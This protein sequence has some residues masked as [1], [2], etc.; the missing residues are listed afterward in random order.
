MKMVVE[1]R[2][3]DEHNLYPPQAEWC[4]YPFLQSEHQWHRY[5]HPRNQSAH[6]HRCGGL[7][8]LKEIH[9]WR[10]RSHLIE[11]EEREY[12]R[13]TEAAHPSSTIAHPCPYGSRRRYRTGTNGKKVFDF[14]KGLIIQGNL[15][16]MKKQS[17]KLWIRQRCIWPQCLMHVVS[18]QMG[19]VDRTTGE[20]SPHQY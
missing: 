12:V 19:P 13:L 15:K 18:D 8:T 3:T 6:R 20:K 4:G 5:D 17:N 16:M 9:A 14:H 1:G 2:S 7:V 11:A 10:L